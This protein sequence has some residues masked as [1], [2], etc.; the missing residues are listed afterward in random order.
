MANASKLAS[1][2]SWIDRSSDLLV[3]RYGGVALPIVAVIALLFG[4][5]FILKPGTYTSAFYQFAFRNVGPRPVGT[6]HLLIAVGVL[7]KPRAVTVGA[8]VA[9]NVTWALVSITAVVLQPGVSAT[10]FAYPVGVAL[11]LFYSVGSRGYGPH[12]TT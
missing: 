3:N 6:A 2:R 7:A 12:G 1:Q 10:A 11:I 4:L 8:L 5:G 9:L